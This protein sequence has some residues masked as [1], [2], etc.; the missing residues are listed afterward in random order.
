MAKEKKCF[1]CNRQL[2]EADDWASFGQDNNNEIL[3]CPDCLT[4]T[5]MVWKFNEAYTDQ[6]AQIEIMNKELKNLRKIEKCLLDI[7]KLLNEPK[8]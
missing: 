7:S 2:D 4:K 8:G 3:I 1:N 6:S 5:N